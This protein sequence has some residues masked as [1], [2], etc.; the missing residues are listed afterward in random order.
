MYHDLEA[1]LL[2][3]EATQAPGVAQTS[4]R[5]HDLVVPFGGDPR[6]RYTARCLRAKPRTRRA[7]AARA[8]LPPSLPYAHILS[9]FP[10]PAHPLPPATPRPTRS[11]TV[12]GGGDDP[13]DISAAAHKSVG[14]LAAIA[15]A[16]GVV[17]PSLA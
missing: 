12:T 6:A 11:I 8:S 13:E 17:R 1:Q 14:L 4:H 5:G 9:I 2:D 10:P 15:V 3:L 16:A 7:P